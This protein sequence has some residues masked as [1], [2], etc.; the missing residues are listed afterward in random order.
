MRSYLYFQKQPHD[1]RALLAE[2]S[3]I[4]HERLVPVTRRIYYKQIQNPELTYFQ[5]N[6]G[7]MGNRPR[8]EHNTTQFFFICLHVKPNGSS[9]TI[10][11]YNA[12]MTRPTKKSV[13]HSYPKLSFLIIMTGIFAGPLIR[14]FGWRKITI[15]GA[16][17]SALGFCS[18]ALVPNIYL[19]YFTYGVLTGNGLFIQPK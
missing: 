12:K 8:C 1:E 2:S 15:A 3:I 19:M 18:S 5:L 10:V 7:V 16:F 17:I 13:L 11:Y 9:K 4:Y 14:K 6:I